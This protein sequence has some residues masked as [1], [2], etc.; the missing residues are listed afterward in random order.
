LPISIA[1]SALSRKALA[2]KKAR[3]ARTAA[4]KTRRP[5]LDILIAWAE[6]DPELHQA[7]TAGYL[8][9]AAQQLL[10]GLARVTKAVA[11]ADRLRDEAGAGDPETIADLL[12]RYRVP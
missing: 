4:N 7:I 10:S 1:G 6:S 5:A 3:A 9:T 8:R 11:K 12:T 2:E